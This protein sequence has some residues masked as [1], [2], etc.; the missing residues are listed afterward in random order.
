MK[1]CPKCGQEM[2][3][4]ARF[5]SNCGHQMFDDYVDDRIRNPYVNNDTNNSGSLGILS[6]VLAF[7]MPIVGLILGILGLKSNNEKERK[8][9]KIGVILSAVFLGLI[10]IIYIFYFIIYGSILFQVLY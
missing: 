2:D 6:I 8:Y 9:S 1:F 7:V 3:D 5:C 10:V 4:D